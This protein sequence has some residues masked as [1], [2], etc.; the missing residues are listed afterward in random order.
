MNIIDVEGIGPDIAASLT[1]AGVGTTEALL[2]RGA[3]A[4]GRSALAAATGISRTSFL[5]GSITPT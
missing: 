1:A 4:A 5:D 2:D 3:T